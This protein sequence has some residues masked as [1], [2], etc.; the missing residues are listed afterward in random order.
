MRKPLQPVNFSS[1]AKKGHYVY[2]YLRV[3][4][5][6][7]YVGISGGSARPTQ[8]HRTRGGGV[9]VPRDKSRIRVLRS[10]L[11]REEACE[12]EMFYI[13]HYGRKDI[14][15][16]ILRNRTD[17]GDNGALGH[18]HSEKHKAYIASVLRGR[19]KSEAMRKKMKAIAS[20]P[21]HKARMLQQCFT[22]ESIEKRTAQLRG[23][24]RSE[25]DCQNISIGKVEGSGIAEECGFTTEEW[26]EL[27]DSQR[28]S[29]RERFADGHTDRTIL[30]LPT[31]IRLDVIRNALKYEMGIEEY[32][33]LS[34]DQ[35]GDLKTAYDRYEV[36]AQKVNISWAE[37]KLLNRA[38]RNSISKVKGTPW[39]DWGITLEQYFSLGKNPKNKIQWRYK[40][41]KRGTDLLQGINL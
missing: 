18:R 15:T 14:G 21:D 27:D 20:T 32:R 11:T 31:E 4:G 30:L 28:R 37:Y 23:R 33:N 29:V 10:G 41:G 36:I 6:P 1:I 13:K 19:K 9:L 24:T 5:S 25:E 7:Y 17:G 40:N 8:N 22:P 3:D 34:K 39:L 38:Q 35:R 26:L 12:W 16:G 2:C